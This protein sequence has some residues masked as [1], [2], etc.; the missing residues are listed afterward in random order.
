MANLSNI[1]GKFVVEQTTGF[2]GIGTTDP[3]YLL[4][5][6]SSD[7]TNGTR[8]II[9]NTNGSGKKYGLLS[10][11]TGVFTVRDITAGADRFSI[12]TLGNATFAGDVIIAEASNKGQL[13]FGTANTDY[14]IKGGG[15]YGY[16]SLNAP[17]LRFDTGGTERMR[18]DSSGNVGINTDSPSDLYADQLVVECSSSENGI[19]ILSNSTTDNNYLMFADGTT[20]D[21]R[22]RGQI[23]YN[24]Q[25][26]FMAFAVNAS[27]KMYI[28]ENGNVGIGR[29]AL[30]NNALTV[31]KTDA[32]SNFYE[33]LAAIEICNS[34]ANVGKWRALNFKVGAGNYSETLAGIYCQYE[35][36]STNVT[37][38]M[39]F[40]TRE[41]NSTN[42]TERMRIDSSGNST[43][44]GNVNISSP[45]DLYINSGTS[46]NNKGSIFMSNQRTEIVSDIVNLTANGDTSLNFKTRSGG[47]TASALFIDEFRNVGIGTDSPAAKLHVSG[48]S[49][50]LML[51][52]PNTTNDIDFRFRENGTNKWNMRY[53]NSTND[54]QFLNQTGTAFVQLELS[55]NGNVGIGTDSPNRKLTISDSV[56][57]NYLVS[58]KWYKGASNFSNPFIVIVSNFTNTSS[59]PQIIIKINLIGHGIS[60]NRA[61]FTESICTYDLTNGDLQQTNISHKTVGTSAVAAGV[62]SVSG[63]SIGF[64]PLRQTNYDQFKIEAD[65]QSYSATF[66]Y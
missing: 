20:G 22:F 45:G 7:V 48:T 56:G 2:V 28:Q 21:D 62:F 66:D 16:L 18:I 27:N 11:N 47:A 34:N 54:L 8:I 13:F 10:D 32:N 65:I 4:H 58:A 9:E 53:Q 43:F 39:V 52:T 37:G 17:I 23:S 24:H 36:F 30:L 33:T 25:T 60:A 55:A 64:T 35:A 63:T 61:Q 50:Q 38:N 26:N 12:S 6:N 42:P 1:N 5:V 29:S 46:Y 41:A 19:T 15:N 3:A 59:Y 51:E 40:A 14:E 49:T 44:A 31:T 57:S